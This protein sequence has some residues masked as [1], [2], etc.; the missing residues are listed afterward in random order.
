MEVT[1][2]MVEDQIKAERWTDRQADTGKDK[3]GEAVNREIE[4]QRMRTS[5]QGQTEGD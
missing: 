4:T 5:K 2:N 3:V 1:V